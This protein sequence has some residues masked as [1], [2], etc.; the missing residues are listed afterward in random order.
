MILNSEYFVRSVF[1]VLPSKLRLSSLVKV[2]AIVPTIDRFKMFARL[3]T[4]LLISDVITS[5]SATMRGKRLYDDLAK[6]INRSKNANTDYATLAIARSFSI[7]E[8]AIR[9]ILKRRIGRSD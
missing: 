5:I 8:S 9:G 4:S 3:G 6:S 2:H 1:L 7:S